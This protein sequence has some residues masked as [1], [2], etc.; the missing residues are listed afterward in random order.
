MDMNLISPFMIACTKML[1]KLKQTCIFQLLDCLSVYNVL[2][3][4]GIK[5]LKAKT[6]HKRNGLLRDILYSIHCMK[7]WLLFNI[8]VLKIFKKFQEKH[9]WQ[10]SYRFSPSK[11][12]W[13]LLNFLTVR[14]GTYWR[15]MLISGPALIWGKT[16]FSIFDNLK[17][18]KCVEYDLCHKCFS[19]NFLKIFRTAFSNNTAGGTFMILSDGSLKISKTSFNP[20]MLGSNKRSYILKQTFN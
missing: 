6:V 5:V 13:P 9:P 8:T 19:R 4:F 1:Y 10:S 14:C 12:P 11:C 18:C 17:V 15:E 2:L 7:I 20:L 16:V 3:P